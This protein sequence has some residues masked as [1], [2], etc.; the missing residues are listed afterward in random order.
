[1]E[2]RKNSCKIRIKLVFFTMSISTIILLLKVIR[3]R[4]TIEVKLLISFRFFN[5]NY[6][7]HIARIFLLLF[8]S[9]CV[10]N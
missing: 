7:T 4:G 1:M 10:N 3:N 8:L 5:S 2:K 9:P 6:R